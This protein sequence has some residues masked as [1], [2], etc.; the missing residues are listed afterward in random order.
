MS[1]ATLTPAVVLPCLAYFQML[2]QRV[3]LA[4]LAI[5]RQFSG[6]PTFKRIPDLLNANG[7]IALQVNSDV[8]DASSSTLTFQSSAFE[9]PS[10]GESEALTLDVGDLEVPKGKLTTIVGPNGAGKSS[11]LQ[12][13]IGEMVETSG[14]CHVNGLLARCSQEPWIVSG[15][16][17]DHVVFNSSRGYDSTRY[18]NAE[19]ACRL[20][21]DV[22]K[23]T[24][25]TQH[26]TVGEA[27]SNLSGGQRARVALARALYSE[28]DILL[29]GEPLSALDANVRVTSSKQFDSV[30]KPSCLVTTTAL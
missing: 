26:A 28:A 29:V 16:L 25:G 1:G 10:T 18:K 17:Q 21:Q 6:N 13:I 8:G 2:Y 23:L 9:W 12:A 15:S 11:L 24:G 7:S 19:R 22:N 5:S 14:A 30:A 4:S 27:G 3:F 20:D